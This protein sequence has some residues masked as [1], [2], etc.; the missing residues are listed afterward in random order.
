MDEELYDVIIIGGGPTGL[1][2]SF[3]AGLRD[4][5]VKIIDSLPQ[6]RWSVN[7]ALS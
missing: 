2:A 4:L 7:G 5:K 1:F 3:Y 6:L